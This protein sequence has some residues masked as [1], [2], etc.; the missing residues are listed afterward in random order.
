MTPG[1]RLP[2]FTSLSILFLL[3]ALSFPGKLHS[4]NELLVAVRH[5]TVLSRLHIRALAVR[6]DS[7]V[8]FAANRGVWGYTRD[9]GKHWH[10]DSL[11]VDTLYA[12]FRSLALINDSTALLL[13]IASPAI[14]DED[15]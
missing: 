5:H 6:N 2:L 7:T 1:I 14:F 13:S 9:G 3:F 8:W 4:Q 10:V 11:K 12:Q 15:K